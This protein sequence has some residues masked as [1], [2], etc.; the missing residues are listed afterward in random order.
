MSTRNDESRDIT[1]LSAAER[2]WLRRQGRAARALETRQRQS[3][4]RAAWRARP[5]GAGR[6]RTRS[7]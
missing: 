7:A 6:K 4:R 2:E 3:E 5:A 1:T